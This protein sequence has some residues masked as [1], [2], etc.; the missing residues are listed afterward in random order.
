MDQVGIDVAADALAKGRVVVLPTDTVYGLAADAYSDSAISEIFR[1]KQRPI[2][3]PIAI[4]FPCLDAAENDVVV[5]GFA[6]FL[7][8]KFLPGPLTIIL[9]RKRASKVSLLC[10]AGL[11][12]LGVRVPSNEIAL[13]LLS[14]L[15][16]PLALTSANISRGASPTSAQEAVI[17]LGKKGKNIPV[18]D[19]GV[20]KIGIE[21]TIV[22]LTGETPIITRVGAIDVATLEHTC[23]TKFFVKNR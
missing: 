23:G 9:K 15:D 6:R 8:D 7:A 21:S 5:T 18:I 4:A 3:S 19:G 20:C 14:S 2:S 10:S 17:A 16:F 12:T 11:D 13:R 1:C 22:D